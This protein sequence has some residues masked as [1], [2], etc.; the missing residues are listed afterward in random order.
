MVTRSCCCSIQGHSV[1][2][3]AVIW[4]DCC[5]CQWLKLSAVNLLQAWSWPK[6]IKRVWCSYC[7]DKHCVAL[8]SPVWAIQRHI[9]AGFFR[10]IYRHYILCHYPPPRSSIICNSFTLTFA[11]G[12]SSLGFIALNSGEEINPLWRWQP[13][14]WSFSDHNWCIAFQYFSW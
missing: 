14:N 10:F 7:N 8:T 2:E 11:V 13:K 4:P 1:F 3:T 5:H 9:F 6:S 12:V